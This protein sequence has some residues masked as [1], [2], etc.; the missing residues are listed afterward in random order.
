MSIKHQ[1]PVY[2]K[3]L[4]QG[5]LGLF[6]PPT[7]SGPL[8]G[9]W[10][11]NFED[12]SEEQRAALYATSPRSSS[13]TRRSIPLPQGSRCGAWTYRG[14]KKGGSLLLVR[15][16]CHSWDCPRCRGKK[17]KRI[18]GLVG[19]RT[20]DQGW[21]LFYQGSYRET[22]RAIS[23]LVKRLRRLVGKLDYLALVA[24]EHE[25]HSIALWLRG[26]I[27]SEKALLEAWMALGGGARLAHIFVGRR[28]D[29][30]KTLGSF[31]DILEAGELHERRL[32]VSRGM[33]GELG[34]RALKQGEEERLE[35]SLLPL[36]LEV[37]L[38]SYLRRGYLVTGTG[39]DWV[40]LRPS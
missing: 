18:K 14:E 39:E 4:S 30:E 20:H 24:S 31:L 33:L 7:P 40:A 9:G 35:W 13:I 19:G 25:E 27:P 21:L 11:G 10:M 32:R 3:G 5:Q 37:V 16:Y 17:L 1:N 29:G 26:G 15:A 38:E 6:H 34:F 22:S 23:L 28:S 8:G 12:L 2:V 36:R